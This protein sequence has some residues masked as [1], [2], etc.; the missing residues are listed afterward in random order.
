MI[1]NL[2]RCVNRAAEANLVFQHKIPF[3]FASFVD[4]LLANS[5][6]SD[7]T[8]AFRDVVSL[9]RS[10]SGASDESEFLISLS[11][12]ITRIDTDLLDELRFIRCSTN[13]PHNILSLAKR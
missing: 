5:D 8:L 11:P 12:R 10:V 13:V 3:S 6:S 1:S 4:F 9:L 7:A 2:R